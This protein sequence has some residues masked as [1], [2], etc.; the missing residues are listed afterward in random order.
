M[1]EEEVNQ[2]NLRKKRILLDSMGVFGQFSRQ[3]GG[4]GVQ[5]LVYTFV[6][7]QKLHHIFSCLSL[8][9]FAD[10]AVPRVRSSDG[11]SPP[12]AQ[13]QGGFLNNDLQFLI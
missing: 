5:S 8:N 3:Q 9:L 13:F 7:F 4:R 2:E 11:C 6:P 10:F 1:E 12:S